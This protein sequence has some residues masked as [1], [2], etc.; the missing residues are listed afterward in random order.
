M[1]R[2]LFASTLATTI[3]RLVTVGLVIF[4]VHAMSVRSTTLAVADASSPIDTLNPGE[5]YEIP[6]SK[7][8]A[9]GVFPN[10]IPAGN[11]GPASLMSAGNSG[12]YDTTRDRLLIWG[13]GHTDYS[14][15]EMYAFDL[16][17]LSWTRIWG[18]TSHIPTSGTWEAY[19][20]GNPGARHTY[21]GQ[22]YIPSASA[23]TSTNMSGPTLTVGGCA[24]AS[25]NAIVFDIAG[26]AATPY[27]EIPH[28]NS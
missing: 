6:N 18:P 25:S 19:P 17:S 20:D 9:A 4:S 7:R 28:E 13:G 12:A 22:T 10:P 3:V 23:L 21:D 24:G 8:S 11:S 5:W 1:K 27:E 14:G 2:T 15:I 26:A 16:N